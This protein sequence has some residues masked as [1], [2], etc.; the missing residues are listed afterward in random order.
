MMKKHPHKEIV[1]C[2]IIG[3]GINGA[4]IAADAAGRGLSVLLCEQYDLGSGTSNWSTKLIHGG[5]RY[6]EHYDF[7]MVRHALQERDCLIGRAPHL[8]K[9]IAFV[10]PHQPHLR[11]RWMI[12]LG[13]F[14]YDH[15]AKSKYVQKSCGIDLRKNTTLKSNYPSGFLY[16][17]CQTQDNKLV[18]LNA[19]SAKQH[20]ATILP[21]TKVQSARVNNHIWETTLVNQLTRDSRVVYSRV[22]INASGPWMNEVLDKV[23]PAATNDTVKLVQ[24]SHIVVPKL[25]D[26]N[27]AYLLQSPDQRVLFTLP[28]EKNYTLIGTTDT[29]IHGCPEKTQITKEE[30]HYL[31]ENINTYFKHSIQEKDIVWSYSGVRALHDS[32]AQSAKNISR[33]YKLSLHTKNTPPLV[34]VLGGKLTTHRKLAEET[35]DKLKFAFPKM[36][37]AWTGTKPLPGGDITGHVEDYLHTCRAQYPWLPKKILEHYIDHYG[38]RVHILLDNCHSFSDLGEAYSS[39]CYE[40]EIRYLLKHEWARSVE[41]I[42]WR[43]TKHGLHLLPHSVQLIQLYCD[44][45]NE[46]HK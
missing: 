20:G 35:M 38:T 44:E 21:H 24:G 12:R 6:L 26:E 42:I 29:P 45:W 13:L 27:N 17:D 28:F 31:I 2:L 14:F 36:G 37:P 33:D 34:N 23:V 5:L 1:D 15:L 43:R 10:L 41:D 9:P 30:I 3:G 19:L 32:D 4:A 25:Y 7:K 46:N 22:I 40:R 11:P 16:Y 8:V 18:I 39:I